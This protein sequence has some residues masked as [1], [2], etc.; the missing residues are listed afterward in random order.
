MA[1]DSAYVPPKVWTW[2]PRGPVASPSSIARPPARRRDAA[3]GRS[4]SAAAVLRAT[5]NGVKVTVLLEELLARGHAGA[6]YD[7]WLIDISRA[8]SSAQASS[9]STRTPRSRR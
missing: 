7:A 1:D 8:N 9:R 6:E 5:P 3:A 4:A 2:N